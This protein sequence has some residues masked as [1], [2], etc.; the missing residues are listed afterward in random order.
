[1]GF[2]KN[3]TRRII[4]SGSTY[5]W[6]VAVDEDWKNPLPPNP[7]DLHSLTVESPDHPGRWLAV[8]FAL[9]EEHTGLAFAIT[10]GLVTAI[11][12]SATALGWPNVGEPWRCIW[13]NG[14]LQVDG[15]G[16][17]SEDQTAG[18]VR[19]NRSKPRRHRP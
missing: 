1:M 15:R 14:Q 10:P 3:G 18:T 19:S 11:I 8:R 9:P 5:L 2:P 12:N 17:A 13:R 4:V 16:A 6:R 7:T